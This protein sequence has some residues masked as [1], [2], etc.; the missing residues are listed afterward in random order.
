MIQTVIFD[1]D[2][3]IVDT[4]PV[5]YY[6]YHKHFKELKAWAKSVEGTGV[7][8]WPQI[9]HPGRQAFAS[10]NREVVAPSAIPLKMG[11]ASKMFTI[12]KALTEEEIWK[13]IDWEK[14]N[15]RFEK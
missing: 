10:I 15:E 6:A 14:I 9:N 3:V 8:I 13:I 12:P 1:M 11:G 7:H 2:G 4:E 5:H